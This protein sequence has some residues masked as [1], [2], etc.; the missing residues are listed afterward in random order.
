MGLQ[1]TRTAVARTSV[2]ARTAT[3][4]QRQTAIAGLQ[5]TRTAVARTSVAVRTATVTA[6]ATS[7]AALIQTRTRVAQTSVATRTATVAS[8]ITP[9]AITPTVQTAVMWTSGE[10]VTRLHEPRAGE[11]C[12]GAQVG[13][14]ERRDTSYIVYFASDTASI[15]ITSGYCELYGRSLADIVSQVRKDYGQLTWQVVSDYA[16]AAPRPQPVRWESGPR[17]QS[18]SPQAGEIC[19]GEY[20]G[21]Y[22]QPGTSYVVYFAENSAPI[23]IF[24]GACERHDRSFSEIVRWVTTEAYPQLRWQVIA[25]YVSN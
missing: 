11:I 19:W 22:R 23:T 12:Y 3:A 5:H 21:R 20:V 18:Y 7:Q 8:R 1:H 25:P 24:H 16:S 14:L 4:G 6:Q 2:A 17:E 9:W 13:K 10:G 15:A